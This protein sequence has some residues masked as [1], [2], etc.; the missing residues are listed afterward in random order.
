MGIK[1][2]ENKAPGSYKCR[3]RNKNQG[4][5]SLSHESKKEAESDP[6]WLGVEMADSTAKN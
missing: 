6:M 5:I 2:S 1:V 4:E 3:G